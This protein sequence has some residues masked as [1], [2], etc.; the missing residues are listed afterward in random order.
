MKSNSPFAVTARY[1]V[2][3]ITAAVLAGCAAYVNPG[4]DPAT[5]EASVQARVNEAV[6]ANYK[7]HSRYSMR[8]PYWLWN[9]YIVRS[10]GYYHELK[11]KGDGPRRWSEGTTLKETVEFLAPAGRYQVRLRV[12]VYLDYNVYGGDDYTTRSITLDE[13]EEDIV[14]D[15]KPGGSLS[16]T[17]KFGG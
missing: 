2:L 14:I 4:P 12:T 13:W 3:I 11:P 9:L 7:E 8:G 10:D 6:V 15:A 1:A 17:R 16:I 5:V